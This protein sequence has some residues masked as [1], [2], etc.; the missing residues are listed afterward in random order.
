M[1]ITTTVKKGYKQTELGVIPKDWEIKQI[2]D[3]APLQRGFDLPTYQL[4]DG[5]YPVVY[6]NGVLNFHQ[7]AMVRAPGVTTGRSGT[8][9]KV[10]FIEK[11]YW[12]HNTTLWVTNFKGND[13]KYIYF[14]YS[15]IKLERFGTGSGVPTLNRN[16]VHTYR[17]CIPK[18]KAEQTA[19]ATIL[20]DTDTLIENLEKLISKKKAIKQGAMQQLL[21]G[22]KRLPGFNVVKEFRRTDLGEIPN[23]WHIA[24]LVNLIDPSRSIRYGIVQPGMFDPNGRYMIRGQDYSEVKGWAKPNELF[25][26]SPIV[27]ERYRN[28]RVKEGDL[29]MTIV[30]YCGYV[31]VVPGW[32]EG[33][34]LTQTT[35]RIA[36]DPNKAS[37]TYC[38]YALLS[39]AGRSQVSLYLKGAAQPGLNIRDVEI[40]KLLLPSSLSEQTAIASILSDIDLEIE[41]LQQKKNKYIV[42]KNGMMQQLLTG[43]IR[44]YG[45]R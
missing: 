20:T 37:S 32:L 42:L 2:I 18:N 5:I 23:D 36:I 9:G 3:I 16:D 1:V 45:N 41:S 39:S 33:A 15:N 30:G 11:D 27:E 26:V 44:V 8:I 25:R 13:E 28:A 17:V 4:K 22:K 34:N 31:E 29:I 7:K 10:N 43:T 38:K 14:L 21:T 19:I 24:P 40:F 12:P 6:S 35:A